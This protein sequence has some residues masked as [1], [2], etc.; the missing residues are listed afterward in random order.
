MNTGLQSLPRGAL[1]RCALVSLSRWRRKAVV[2][3]G[4]RIPLDRASHQARVS[5]NVN[6]RAPEYGRP[7]LVWDMVQDVWQAGSR[8]AVPAKTESSLSGWRQDLRQRL[9]HGIACRSGAQGWRRVGG[10]RA[11]DR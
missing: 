11:P 5:F 4:A 8:R 2:W 10:R 1:R 3:D 9:G 7:R 6:V